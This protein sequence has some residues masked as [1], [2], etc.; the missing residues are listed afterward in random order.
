MKSEDSIPIVF[1]VT[2]SGGG[3]VEM[4]S[5]QLQAEVR[6]QIDVVHAFNY[7]CSFQLVALLTWT[8]SRTG[9]PYL[10]QLSL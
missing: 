2:W 10:F 6:V 8:L 7:S 1:F 9:H 4:L 3:I 5:E